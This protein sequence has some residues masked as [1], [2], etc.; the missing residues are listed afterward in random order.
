MRSMTLHGTAAA[1]LSLGLLVGAGPALAVAPPAFGGLYVFG[2]SLSDAAGGSNTNPFAPNE[3]GLAIPFPY[4]GGRVSNG[5]VAAEYLGGALGLS[6]AQQFHFAIAGARTGATGATDPTG[7][8]TQVGAFALGGAQAAYG[9]GLFMVWA[10]ANDLRDAFEAAASGGP[11][12]FD[13]FAGTIGNLQSAVTTLYGLGARSFLLPN[14]PD[15]GRTPEVLANGPAAS[16]QVS[17][18][19]DEFNTQ[20]EA[21]YVG[22]AATLPGAT[23]FQ[24][25]TFA[26]HGALADGAPG[27]GYLNL[28]NGCLVPVAGAAQA[29]SDCS[30]SF[31]VDNIHPTTSVHMTLGLQMAAAVPEPG[32]ML[33]MALGGLALL[34][35]QRRRAG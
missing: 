2:D 9:G 15:L 22:L 6:D 35:L 26:A 10:G 3:G 8:Q 25:D 23:L 24:F 14:I 31:F 16:G 28:T 13:S 12:P 21:A 17:F 30:V 1:L 32:T 27:N 11:N 18:V 34:G 29:Q 19:T 7:L 33:M 20:L 4:N 5:P